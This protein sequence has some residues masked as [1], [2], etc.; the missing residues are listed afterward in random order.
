MTKEHQSAVVVRLVLPF[1]H[2]TERRRRRACP[3]DGH[4]ETVV[5]HAV[6]DCLTAVGYA[7][8]AAERVAVVELAR[9]AASLAKG[10]A[11]RPH[12]R[13]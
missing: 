3:T 2:E 6:C 12:C 4:S 1:A 8:G 13:P 5:E 7:S 11:C 10:R 9:R